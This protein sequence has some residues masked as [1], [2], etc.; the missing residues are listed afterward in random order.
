MSNAVNARG[1]AAIHVA[2]GRRLGRAGIA[3]VLG[4]LVPVGLWMSLAELSMAVVAPASVT[5]PVAAR[6]LVRV[7]CSPS[8]EA[9][10]SPSPRPGTSSRPTLVD[11]RND[12]RGR[13]ASAAPSRRSDSP[14]P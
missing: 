4:A 6:S 2:Q 11:T 9:R 14:R 13:P 10:S 8:P 7:T 1:A 3:I 5:A 12:S